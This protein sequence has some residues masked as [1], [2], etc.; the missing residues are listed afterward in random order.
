MPKPF[1]RNPL[2]LPDEVTLHSRPVTPELAKAIAARITAFHT[3][4]A[5]TADQRLEVVGR[6]SGGAAPTL[7]TRQ[8]AEL[9]LAIAEM[10]GEH[11]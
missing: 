11:P 5:D 1:D 2:A 4:P 7:N 8:G 9:L 6:A 10:L 3:G